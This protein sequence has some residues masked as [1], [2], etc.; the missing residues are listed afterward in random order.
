V[1]ILADANAHHPAWNPR[2]ALL[3]NHYGNLLNDFC[4]SNHLSVLNSSL[5]FGVPTFPQSGSVI[6]LALCSDPSLL[7]S[8]IPDPDLDMISDHVPLHLSL[9]VSRDFDAPR[10]H[11]RWAFESADW[12]LFRQL[13]EEQQVSVALGLNRASEGHRLGRLSAQ[14][15]IDAMW[16][17]FKSALLDCAH[18]AVG[19]KEVD[20]SRQPRMPSDVRALLKAYTRAAR[21]RSR[22]RDAASES[23]YV[24]A[25]SAWLRGHEQWQS[26]VWSDRAASSVE[27]PKPSQNRVFAAWARLT[28]PRSLPVNS[29]VDEKGT[30]APSP[31]AALDLIASHFADCSK[32]PREEQMS[33]EHAS[34]RAESNQALCDN[35]PLNLRIGFAE[36]KAACF[37]GGVDVALG[38]DR[39]SPHFLR[40]A[41]DALLS[42]LANMFNFSVAHAVLPA[43]WKVANVTPLFKSG[44]RRQRSNYRPISLTSVVAKALERCIRSR[45]WEIV[46]SKISN[47]Q[48]GFRDQFSTHDQL[49][50]LQSAIYDALEGRHAVSSAMRY[51]SIA[52]LDISKAFDSVWHEGLVAKLA[53]MGVSGALLR[54]IHAFISDRNIRVAHN[55]LFSD[56]FRVTAGVP[57]GCIL[58]PLLFLVFIN[59]LLENLHK[60]ACEAALFAD[61]VAVW[62]NEHLGQTGDDDVS[63]T[64][65]HFAVWAALWH[66][67]F[68][69]KKSVFVCFYF[70]KVRPPDAKVRIQLGTADLER[71]AC[72]KYLGTRFSE[73]CDWNEHFCRLVGSITGLAVLLSRVITPIAPPATVVRTLVHALMYP[74]I[75]YSMP[76]W[77]PTK[78][79]ADRLDS[80]IAWPL[81]RVMGLPRS[82]HT[83]SALADFGLLPVSLL[84]EQS[85]ARFGVRALHL[86][87]PR[88]PTRELY[89]IQYASDES[90]R[91]LRRLSAGF[92]GRQLGA[93]LKLDFRKCSRKEL[94]SCL[95]SRCFADWT[96]DAQSAKLLKS[97]RDSCSFASYLQLETRGDAAIRAQFRH[98]RVATNRRAALLDPSLSAS[99]S[100]C[101]AA[102]ENVEHILLLCPAYSSARNMCS[103]RLGA[104]NVFDDVPDSF[105]VSFLLGELSSGLK[106]DI[107][108]ELLGI[109]MRYLRSIVTQRKLLL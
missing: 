14:A 34:I 50:R 76:F 30:V 6:D 109:S 104:T 38:P 99:C 33:A 96:S 83:R 3:D 48:A 71:V 77:R 12:V 75:S 25:R 52:F 28:R 41:P 27:A 82:S 68:N 88:H 81:R 8:L 85:A 74:V 42:L 108:S 78:A 94:D 79:Q 66:V 13:L 84:W 35:S 103:L 72:F 4:M 15:A 43:D 11:V 64:L 70:G 47:R 51:L 46:R 95:A 58:S 105:N 102:V 86:S 32:A 92:L 63:F 19:E 18:F 17:S 97:T 9:A 54:W 61:D 7:H 45:L 98:N 62:S 67:A 37:K 60:S 93:E 44:D 21:I 55:N 23:A 20:P 80:L 49:F 56:W 10:P 31:K 1:L 22:C 90:E 40:N 59:D 39:I 100:F 24:S 101:N 87:V 89:L 29:I 69:R 57:Q 106:D 16:S 65:G 36:A 53:R 73:R 107:R 2:A 26:K 91:A 5:C